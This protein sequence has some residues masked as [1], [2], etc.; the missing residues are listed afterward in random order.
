[1]KVTISF[2]AFLFFHGNTSFGKVQDSLSHHHPIPREQALGSKSLPALRKIANGALKVTS[3][4]VE[5]TLY[6]F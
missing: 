6:Q 4:Q 5:E 1:M 2:N 3:L